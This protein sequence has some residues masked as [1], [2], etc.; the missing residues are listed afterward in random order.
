MNRREFINCVSS[1]GALSS[2]ISHNKK[3]KN[4]ISVNVNGK[5]GLGT[6]TPNKHLIINN[7][8]TS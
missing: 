4:C 8:I 2:I 1:I 5:V 3:D 6:S 7:E